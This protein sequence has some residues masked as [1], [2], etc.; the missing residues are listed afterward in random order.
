VI[1]RGVIPAVALLCALLAPASMAKGQLQARP[2]L[3]ELAPGATAA[4]MILANTG[5]APVSAQVRVFAWTQADGEDRLADTRAIAL[6]PP[7]VRIPPGGEQVVR[8]VRQ[9]PAAAGEGSYRLVVD[10]LPAP[11]ATGEASGIAFRMRYVLPLF[12]RAAGAS[13]PDLRCRL[14]GVQ[15]SCDNRGGRAAQLGS[16]RLRDAGGHAVTLSPGL[17]GYVLAGS[18]RRWTLGA[19]S[20]TALG[21]ELQ[22]ETRLNGQPVTIP[23]ARVP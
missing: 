19:A 3:V 5:D 7:I 16:S 12:V 2:T 10:E 21:S 18:S 15:F 14:A 8:I 11:P 6:S 17:F 4:R 20:L 23:V 22:L 1:R 9:G 13:A